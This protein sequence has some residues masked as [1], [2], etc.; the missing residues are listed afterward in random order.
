MGGRLSSL[1]ACI[2]ALGVAGCAGEPAPDSA[3]TA[4]LVLDPSVQ[5]AV[6]A[7]L[8]DYRPTAMITALSQT[9]EIDNVGNFGKLVYFQ[10]HSAYARQDNGLWEAAGGGGFTNG[11]ASGGG[12]SLV[13]CGLVVLL[14]NSGSTSS[15][16]T[17]GAALAGKTFVSFGINAP[18]QFGVRRRVTKLETTAHLCTPAPGASFSYHVEAEAWVKVSGLFGQTRHVTA[19]T[20]VT[21]HV[22]PNPTPAAAILPGFRGDA[23]HVSCETVVGSGSPHKSEYAFLRDAGLYLQLSIGEPGDV[24]TTKIRYDAVSYSP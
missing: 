6:R 8:S 1:F 18:V 11:D 22:A 12:E 19:V 7:T 24:Q 3:M 15:V 2:L 13:L 10:A 20:D 21:C 4:P 5:Q 16:T 9:Q 14:N 23:L 17:G